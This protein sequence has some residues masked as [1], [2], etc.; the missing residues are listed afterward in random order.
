VRDAYA[1]LRL[2][3]IGRGCLRC[4]GAIDPERVR[5]ELLTEDERAQQ[6][7]YGYTPGIRMPAP[8]VLPLNAFAVSLLTMRLF[9]LLEP[10]LDWDDRVTVELRS[11]AVTERAAT[12]R[13]GCDVCDEPTRLGRGDDYVLAC[14]P[15]PAMKGG[16]DAESRS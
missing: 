1:E 11:L 4:Q 7:Q 14:R 9:D 10:W 16:S 8:S 15:D 3:T 5:Q 12:S 6:Q 13:T 2:V